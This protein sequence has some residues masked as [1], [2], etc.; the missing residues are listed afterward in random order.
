MASDYCSIDGDDIDPNSP[1]GGGGPGFF[2]VRKPPGPMCGIRQGGKG[3]TRM[4]GMETCKA[5]MRYTLPQAHKRALEKLSFTQKYF[6]DVRKTFE[7]GTTLNEVA[8]T[9]ER[10]KANLLNSYWGLYVDPA[11]RKFKGLDPS[12]SKQQFAKEFIVPLNS[13][14]AVYGKTY[15]G[16]SQ[17]DFQYECEYKG[18]YFYQFLSCSDPS[19]V[20]GYVRAV[21][22]LP[23]GGI[24]LCVDVFKDHGDVEAF[25][26][27][28]IHEASHRFAG[29]DDTSDVPWKNAHVVTMGMPAE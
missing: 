24:H 28:I 7:I 23:F 27:T 25:A 5:Q 16:L 22:G 3:K 6:A 17:G 9:L 20:Q 15:D 13:I 14:L 26:D 21:A 12:P 29:T 4:P 1:A 19:G 18:D 11:M 2:S 8:S 10:R